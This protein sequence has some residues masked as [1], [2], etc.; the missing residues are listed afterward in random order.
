M[1]NKIRYRIGTLT[2]AEDVARVNIDTWRSCF[3]GLVPSS[4]LE[5]MSIEK[6]AAALRKRFENE[7]YGLFVAEN[8]AGHIVGFCDFGTPRQSKWSYD[9]EL[10]AIYVLHDYQRKG[11][12]RILFSRAANAILEQ[13]K[14]SLFVRVLEFNPYRVFYNNLCDE[15]IDM[16]S[17][18]LDGKRVNNAIYS[19]NDLRDWQ[20]KQYT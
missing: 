11:I 14:N 15:V 2:D 13:R 6:R 10:Y 18:E 9:M 3:R 7:H 20:T 17:I 4:F 16:E 5:S 19:W 1:R 8:E 12:G